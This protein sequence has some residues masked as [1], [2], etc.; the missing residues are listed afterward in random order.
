MESDVLVVVSAEDLPTLPIPLRAVVT[1][2]MK[3]KV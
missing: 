2:D 3:S 1:R